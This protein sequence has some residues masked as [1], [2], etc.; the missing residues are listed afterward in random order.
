MA[1]GILCFGIM[2][3]MHIRRGNIRAN[4]II[5]HNI[6]LGWEGYHVQKFKLWWTKELTVAVVYHNGYGLRMQHSCWWYEFQSSNK[7]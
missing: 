6:I 2:L 7:G 5:I 3:N 1:T 4:S